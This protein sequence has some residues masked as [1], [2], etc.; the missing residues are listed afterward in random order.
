DGGTDDGGLNACGDFDPSCTDRGFGPGKGFPFPLSTDKPP[1]PNETDD[2]IGRDMSGYLG[3]NTSKA[4][5]D[6]LW[7][8]N[9]GDL[10]GTGTTS[11]L[12]SK[13]VREVARYYT[14]T[15]YSNQGGS[16][17]M[18]DGTN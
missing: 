7:I 2:G 5:F 6:Y 10:S 3:L 15:C 14:V 9:S 13:T 4:S 16:T 11:K 1:D 18:C 8:A 17:A 12:N